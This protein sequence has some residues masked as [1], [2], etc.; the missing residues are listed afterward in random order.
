MGTNTLYIDI[1]LDQKKVIAD[2]KK[3]EQELKKREKAINDKV[4]IKPTVDTKPAEKK[5][6]DF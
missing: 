3:L 1:E 2:L 5:L 6:D 4:K